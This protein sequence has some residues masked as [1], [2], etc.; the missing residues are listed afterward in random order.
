MSSIGLD[1]YR[2]NWRTAR[3]SAGNGACVE[4]AAAGRHVLVRDSK[5]RDGSVM[6]YPGDAWQAFLA[7]AKNGHLDL[8]CR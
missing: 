2:L 7:K 6:Q 3:R 5:D 1:I 8:D 4:V